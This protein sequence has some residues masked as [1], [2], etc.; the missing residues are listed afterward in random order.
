MAIDLQAEEL[1]SLTDAAKALPPIDGKRPHVSTIWRWVRR[2]VRGI[3]LEHV[4]LGHRVCTS[5]EA[6]A[7]FAQRLADADDRAVGRPV[8]RLQTKPTRTA[9]KRQRAVESAENELT[10]LGI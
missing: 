7:R 4:R 6:L 3:R 5:Q 1:L 8:G 9:A 2:G 10:Q